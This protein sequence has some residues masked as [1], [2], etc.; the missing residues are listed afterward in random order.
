MEKFSSGP[1][2]A[3]RFKQIEWAE[4]MEELN[5]QKDYAA[6]EYR[7]PHRDYLG[8]QMAKFEHN[9]GQYLPPQQHPAYARPP[10]NYSQQ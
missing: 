6:R 3:E 8:E 7:E 9:A 2:L 10:S 1:S 5:K 4:N